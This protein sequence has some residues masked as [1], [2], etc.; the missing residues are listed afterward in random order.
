MSNRLHLPHRFQT[1]HLVGIV[2]AV[3]VLLLVGLRLTGLSSRLNQ[4]AGN[5][6]ALRAAM[7]ATPALLNE[8]TD[9][10]VVTDDMVENGLQARAYA[11]A[12][13][14]D[15]HP[16][17]AE[18]LLLSGLND[19]ASAYLT[20]FQLCDLYWELGLH[21]QALQACQGT[22]LSADYWLGEGFKALDDSRP[23]DALSLF[24]LAAYTDPD[25]SEA[26]RHYGSAFCWPPVV[27]AGRGSVE[28]VLFS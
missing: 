14:A 3:L 21:S 18:A 26:W 13:T 7:S 24:E 12:A 28:R 8:S 19:P 9:D 23:A 5:P 1:H 6:A 11:H 25:M 16:T 2:T 27:P 4:T 17:E 15:G 10:P 22:I 20:Q